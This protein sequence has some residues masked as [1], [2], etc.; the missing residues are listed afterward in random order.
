LLG[1]A[2]CGVAS[3][4]R[5]KRQKKKYNIQMSA[6]IGHRILAYPEINSTNRLAAT[7][8]NDPANHGLVITADAQTAGRGQYDRTW[9]APAGSSILMSVV[10]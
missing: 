3:L 9:Q 7:F 2:A 6:P 8:A 1:F 10:L 5:R 4:R